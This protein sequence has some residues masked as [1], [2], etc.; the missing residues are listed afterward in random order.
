[1]NS[2]YSIE[3]LIAEAKSMMNDNLDAAVK[4]CLLAAELAEESKD[5]AL[6]GDARHL[7][8]QF[9]FMQGNHITAIEEKAIGLTR[10]ASG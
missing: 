2:T 5:A 10:V 6:E 1:M 9:Y 8:S 4:K 7:L 3:S